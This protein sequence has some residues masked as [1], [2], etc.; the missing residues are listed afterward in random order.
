[1]T[2]LGPNFEV[3]NNLECKKRIINGL[4][5]VENLGIGTKMR[6]Y[7]LLFQKYGD[8][9]YFG[10]FWVEGPILALLEPDCRVN[11]NC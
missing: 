9:T 3:T 11:N 7:V 8:F 10:I 4:S 6:I 2:L 1:M 5:G